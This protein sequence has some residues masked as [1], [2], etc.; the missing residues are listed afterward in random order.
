[1]QSASS[2]RGCRSA[3]GNCPNAIDMRVSNVAVATSPPIGGGF[4]QRLRQTALAGADH[5]EKGLCS[6]HRAKRVEAALEKR[7]RSASPAARAGPRIKCRVRRSKGLRVKRS[8]DRTVH[9]NARQP[10]GQ[11][12]LTRPGGAGA[13]ILLPI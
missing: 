5:V 2:R 12:L 13:G 9:S 7:R 11:G 10:F 8:S 6:M 3:T 1:M 4:K